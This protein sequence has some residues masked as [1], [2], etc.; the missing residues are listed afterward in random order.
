MCFHF[1][2]KLTSMGVSSGL[3]FGVRGSLVEHSVATR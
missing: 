3:G 1:L 2:D